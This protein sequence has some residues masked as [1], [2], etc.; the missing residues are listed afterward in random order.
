MKNFSIKTLAVALV[1]VGLIA[2]AITVS[3]I[4]ASADITRGTVVH[5]P[6][7]KLA[8]SDEQTIAGKG[9]YTI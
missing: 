1:S 3:V 2:G 9:D 7:P 5:V 4:T 6:V 8:S